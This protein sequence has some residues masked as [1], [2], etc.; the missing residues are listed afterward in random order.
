LWGLKEISLWKLL[1][2]KPIKA[3]EFAV[4]GML[5]K[6]K[7]RQHMI[8]RLKL[9]TWNEHSYIAQKPETLSL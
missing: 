2:K 4:K 5:P 8:A 1:E 9:V 7:L 6:N 3:V